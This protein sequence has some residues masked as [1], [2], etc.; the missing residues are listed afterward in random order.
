MST[1]RSVTLLVLIFIGMV[2]HSVYGWH[3]NSVVRAKFQQYLDDHQCKA[4]GLE[5]VGYDDERDSEIINMSYDCKRGDIRTLRE[6]VISEE[7]KNER[8]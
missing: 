7:V 3:E 6:F 1:D 8:R 4:A 5:V 2:A